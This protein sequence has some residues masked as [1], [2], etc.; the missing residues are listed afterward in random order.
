MSS[1]GQVLV[2]YSSSALS[3]AG[4]EAFRWSATNGMTALGGLPRSFSSF[5]Y[6]VSEDGLVIVGYSS[7]SNNNRHFAGRKSRNDW[8]GE[9]ARRRCPQFANA[10]SGDGAV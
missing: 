10:V 6:A 5:A 7:S 9:F 3:G 1:N 8:L 4:Y 2:G